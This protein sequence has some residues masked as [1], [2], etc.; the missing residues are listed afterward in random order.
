MSGKANFS[1]ALVGNPNAGKTTLFNYLTGLSQRVGNWAGVTV[2]K[3]TGLLKLEINQNPEEVCVVDLPGIYDFSILN[4]KNLELSE[5][6]FDEQISFNYLIGQ[7]EDAPRCILNIVDASHLER[8]LYLTTQLK[9]LGLPMIIVLNMVDVAANMG[10][11]I[12]AEKL[13]LATGC[14]VVSTDLRRKKGL[15]D[16]KKALTEIL[17]VSEVKSEVKSGIKPGIKRDQETHLQ[18]HQEIN[19]ETYKIEEVKTSPRKN[20]DPAERYAIIKSWL[21]SCYQLGPMR[22]HLTPWLDKIVLNRYLGVPI[23]FFLMYLMFEISITI[24][25]ALQPIFNEGSRLLFVDSLIQLFSYLS[26]PAWLIGLLSEGVGVGLNTVMTFIPQVGLLFLCLSFLEDSGYMARAAFVMD[27]VMQAVGLPGKSFVPLIIGFGCNVPAIMATRTL[28]SRDRLLTIIMSPFMSCGARLA[29][30]AVFATAFFPRSGAWVVFLLYFLGVLIAFLTALVVRKTILK[31]KSVPFMIEL[32]NYHWPKLGMIFHATWLR[33][34]NFLYR[35]GLVIIPVCLVI[36]TLN[37]I[38]TNGQFVPGGSPDSVLSHLS[39]RITP[40]FSPMGIQPENWPATVGLVTGALAKEVVVG[41]MNT[42]YTQANSQANNAKRANQ[43]NQIN[44]INQEQNNK[45]AGLNFTEA[46]QQV[47]W[48]AWNGLTHM[49][50]ESWLNPFS[51]NEAE[52]EMPSSAMGYM[53]KDF[54]SPLAAFAFMLFVLLYVPCVSTI[55]V[56][57]KESGMR[58]ALLST[59]WSLSIAYVFAVMIYQIGLWFEGFS[60]AQPA[61]IFGGLAYLMLFIFGMKKFAFWFRGGEKI[62]VG[63]EGSEAKACAGCHCK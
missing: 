33:L 13:A 26:W 44:Q 27:R 53:V 43:I 5:S 46:L 21:S 34:K 59:L 56:T 11:Y 6:S 1:V 3:K 63:R 25:G 2:E 7:G 62:S 42:L 52:H 60:W 39:Q 49:P 51:A 38:K 15:D 17:S 12:H 8:N 23:F 54:G 19:Q 16:L 50:L 45:P 28:D 18:D 48:D 40:I 61:W 31:G 35:A 55:A 32:P 57:A 36:G 10:I 41:T 37:T 14:R 22:S 4:Q 20:S 58:W 9:E 30:F 24:G 29:I 47:A